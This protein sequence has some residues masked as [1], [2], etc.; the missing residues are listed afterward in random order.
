MNRIETLRAAIEARQV[1]I[2]TLLAN[3]DITAED[4]E[5]VRSLL[6]EQE[7]DHAA[8]TELAELHERAANAA[9]V[10]TVPQII[11]PATPAAEVDALRDS[12]TAVRDA[13]LRIVEDAFWLDS[14]QQTDVEKLLRCSTS[15]TDG[16]LLAR[17]TVATERPEYR[18]AFFKYVAGRGD[19]LTSDERQ[20]VSEYRT[21]V[22]GSMD[23]SGGFGVPV[24]IDP[25]ILITDGYNGPGI[26]P[27]C[28]IEN[29]T[30]D[31]W[32][33][34][35]AAN[36]AWSF[37]AESVDGAIVEVSEDGPTMAQPTVSVHVF[38]FFDYRLK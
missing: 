9:K 24:T 3:D 12:P 20:A 37:D 5:R 7:A 21:G 8:V 13:A 4:T 38:F 28:R 32:R 2:D 26:L 16:S 25:T 17:R 18:S 33:G 34:V 27:Y 30:T 31:A 23:T 19:E 1:E 36:T 35:S 22:A 15:H 29:V 6:D 14:H 10:P 11:R